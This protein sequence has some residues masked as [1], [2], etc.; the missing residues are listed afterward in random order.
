MLTEPAYQ[1]AAEATPQITKLAREISRDL[2][3]LYRSMLGVLGME[4]QPVIVGLGKERWQP[5]V[6][7]ISRY[8]HVIAYIPSLQQF[9]DV[10]AGPRWDVGVLPSNLSH[11]TGLNL[12]TGKLVETPNSTEWRGELAETE[13]QLS[14]TGSALASTLGTLRGDFVAAHATL[15]RMAEQPKRV[16]AFLKLSG[17]EGT[18]TMQ[19]MDNESNGSHL[20]YSA[21]YRLQI[22]RPSQNKWD[23]PLPLGLSFAPRAASQ[24]ADLQHARSLCIPF[25]LTLRTSIKPPQGYLIEK[26]PADAAFDSG[27]GRFSIRYRLSEG[28]LEVTRELIS[29]PTRM[30]CTREEGQQFA[31]LDEPMERA[32][33]QQIVLRR[34]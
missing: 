12:R 31:R 28:A 25:H 24:L 23:M 16:S 4:V 29:N 26:V 9:V 2:V 27:R 19:V 20:R 6:P 17:M 32:L 21:N 34:R 15:S 13:I 3:A 11:K 1:S 8:D 30:I 14:D 10:T 33:Q 5:Q 18:G 7:S 22:P